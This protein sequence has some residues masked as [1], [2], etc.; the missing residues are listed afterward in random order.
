MDSWEDADDLYVIQCGVHTSAMRANLYVDDVPDPFD[1]YE[2]VSLV[3]PS[4]E[5]GIEPQHLIITQTSSD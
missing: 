3:H 1:T 5:V 2:N 4:G